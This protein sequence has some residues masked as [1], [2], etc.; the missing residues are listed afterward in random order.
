MACSYPITHTAAGP[1][2]LCPLRWDDACQRD[3]VRLSR[4]LDGLIRRQG[5]SLGSPVTADMVEECRQEMLLLLWRLRGKL[6][7]LPAGQRDAYAVTCL[8]R[9]SRHFLQRERQRH[10]RSVPL[11]EL[12]TGPGRV[13]EPGGD[14]AQAAPFAADL[15]QQISRADVAEALCSLS[16]RDYA[17][18]DLSYRASLTDAEIAQ[19][20][21]LSA[22]AVKA[23]R[24]RV[25]AKLRH[26]LQAAAAGPGTH[27]R[28]PVGRRLE[29]GADAASSAFAAVVDPPQDRR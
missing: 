21:Q 25:L 1:T 5:L 12:E 7:A 14:A 17:V 20:L 6:D 28:R 9:A 23:R 27:P 2:A 10:A 22:A 18:L 8:S 4:R 29:R 16:R 11:E 19:R 13:A 3:T 24:N 15:L 26:V